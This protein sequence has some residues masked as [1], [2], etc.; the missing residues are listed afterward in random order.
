MDP[1]V[2][3]RLTEFKRDLPR[4]VASRIVR[5]Y[6]TFGECY[7]LNEDQHFGLKS[8]I[9]QQFQIHPNEVVVV[10]SGKLGFSIA[11][12]KRYRPF[13]NTSDIDIAVV[14]SRLFDDI[15]K[16]VFDYWDKNRYWN[17]LDNFKRYLFEGWIRPDV[18][19]QRSFSLTKD[20][21]EFFRQLTSAGSYGPYK[22][23]AG[24]YKSWDFLESYQSIAVKQC[25]QELEID[26]EDNSNK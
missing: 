12:N 23:S 17:G 26:R 20:W 18:L 16:Q 9:A 6:I 24:L 19:P 14:S 22:I 3:T 1:L 15:W 13:A 10:G 8:E 21:W 11:K 4:M 2:L 5:R 7:V 25:Q